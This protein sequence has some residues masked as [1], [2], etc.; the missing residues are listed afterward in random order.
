MTVTFETLSAIYRIA[1]YFIYADGEMT[2]DEV[3]PL[4]DFFGTFPDID[5]EKLD[6]IMDNGEK[7]TDARAIEL[8]SGLDED[9]KQQM[10]NL[11]AK[12][13]CVDGELTD[14]EKRLFFRVRDLCNLPDPQSDDSAE[15]EESGQ[16]PAAAPAP[17]PA[18]EEEDD[19]IMPAF[20]VVTFQGFCSFEQSPNRDWGT[21][22]G[23][24]AEWIGADG[25]EV[26]RYTPALNKLSEQLRLN[27][28]HLVFMVARNGY[29]DKT[30]GDN[31]PA[32]ILYGR[33]YPLY[34]NIVFALETDQ[35]YEIEGIITKKLLLETANAINEAVDGLLRMKQ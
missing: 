33:G 21:L 18:A 7:M 22:G 30:V 11:F 31:M 2:Q 32:T 24:L 9:G 13:I 35:G 10:A 16:A 6:F 8:I 20:I 28:R 14:D 23:E 27:Q 34:G 1:K 25:V 4:F 29:G 15:E 17:A 5:K 26:V 3:K 12:I 19:T